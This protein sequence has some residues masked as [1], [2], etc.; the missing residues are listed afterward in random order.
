MKTT[1]LNDNTSKMLQAIKSTNGSLLTISRDVV[2]QATQEKLLHKV[3]EHVSRRGNQNTYYQIKGKN[4]VL[5]HVQSDMYVLISRYVY[6]AWTDELVDVIPYLLHFSF[7]AGRTGSNRCHVMATCPEN[8]KR[9]GGFSKSVYLTRVLMSLERFGT[10]MN[11]RT[12]DDIHHKG[13]CFDNRQLMIMMVPSSK[14]THR[15]SH[16]T[17]KLI[18]SYQQFMNDLNW[19]SYKYTEVSPVTEVA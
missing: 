16:M 17:G 1:Q 7:Y 14:H 19:M 13:D 8:I 12:D 9:A 15:N 18:S 2:Q 10:L 6:C 11:L 4:D 3:A 5:M